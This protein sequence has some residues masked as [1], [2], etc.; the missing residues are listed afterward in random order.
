MKKLFIIGVLTI[1]NFQIYALFFE[2]AMNQES[3]IQDP[4]KLKFILSYNRLNPKEYGINSKEQ[5]KDS[6]KKI[7]ERLAALIRLA[8]SKNRSIKTEIQSL[9]KKLDAPIVHECA[10]IAERLRAGKPAGTIR[11][12]DTF[13]GWS[14]RTDAAVFYENACDCNFYNSLTSKE[15]EEL[16]NGTQPQGLIQKLLSNL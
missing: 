10:S 14:S 13:T 3:S 2:N 12:T 11:G 16:K 5:A 9:D 1:F 7:H 4:E 15:L 6:A 8:K